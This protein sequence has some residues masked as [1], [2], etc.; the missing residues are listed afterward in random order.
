MITGDIPSVSTTNS[1]D[2]TQPTNKSLKRSAQQPKLEAA[3]SHQ[4][5]KRTAPYGGAWTTVAIFEREEEQEEGDGKGN[6]EVKTEE[7]GGGEDKIQFEEKMMPGV[8]GREENLTEF[9][10]SNLK[11]FSFKKRTTKD[12]TKMRPRSSDVM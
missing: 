12:R 3:Q 5:P 1:S 4:F 6:E 11:S 2:S 10:K 8:L 9:N 7:R